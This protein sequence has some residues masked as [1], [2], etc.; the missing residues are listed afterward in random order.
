[1][2][3]SKKLRGSLELDCHRFAVLKQRQTAVM[4]VLLLG[5]NFIHFEA[6]AKLF[7]V[8]VCVHLKR[9]AA[10]GGRMKNSI[11]PV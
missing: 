7:L 10:W 6:K 2:I 9:E 11:D 1:M 8:R 4:N 5:K 3:T